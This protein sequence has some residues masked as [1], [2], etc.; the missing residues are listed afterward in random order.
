MRADFF[1]PS[2]DTTWNRQRLEAAAPDYTHHTSTSATGP[3]S[4]T[5]SRGGYEL[6]IHAAA[7][8]SHDL[9][10]SR[11]FDDFDVNAGGTLACSRPAAARPE[12]VFIHM[13]PTRSTA[14]TPTVSPGRARD[15]VRL[16]PRRRRRRAH[17]RGHHR[18][19]SLDHCTHS[20][21][22]VSKVASDVI[23]QEY[24]RYF[25]M[26]H[27]GVPGRLPDRAPPLGRGA[28]RLPQL[29]GHP[30]AGRGR[31]H[32]DRPQ[33]EAGPRPDPLHDVITAFWAFAQD[34]RPG[35][36]YN[37]GGGRH[38]A[39]SN[40][41]CVEL[42]AEA[43]GGKRPRLS[44]RRRGP[45]RRP[46]RYYTDMSKFRSHYPAGPRGTRSRRSSTRWSTT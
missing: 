44:F 4:T 46:H 32:D 28:A 2:G 22:G 45:G 37:L 35:E 29:P 14:T 7:Q 8:P 16:R 39:A 5:W 1:G 9:A 3:R 12:A 23:T 20:L 36:A 18:D 42:I 6:V 43:S 34:P 26:K 21:F 40:L 27:R 13:A 17:Q 41:E 10:A 30:G 33:G 31:L 15:P 11:P 38:N 25:G 19:L 24:G